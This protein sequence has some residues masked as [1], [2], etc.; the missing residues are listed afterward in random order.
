MAGPSRLAG[1]LLLGLV[2]CASGAEAERYETLS[3]SALGTTWTVTWRVQDAALSAVVQGEVDLAL[4]EVDAAMSTWRDDSELAAIR[5]GGV[6]PVSE[7]TADV[8]RVALQIAEASGGAF[9]PTVQPLMEL[10]GF[11]GPVPS[12]W[13]SEQAIAEARAQIGWGRVQLGRDEAGRA[14]VDAGGAALDL[15]AIAKGH[16][17]DRV[18]TGLVQLG[19][20]DLFVEVG[21]E[22][23]AHGRSPRGDAWRV[24]VERPEQGL[25]R[26]EVLL[27]L[28]FTNRAVATSGN[29]RNHHE[30]EGRSV[31]HTM[32][33][34][35]GEASRSDVLSA[36]VFAPDCR[37]AD[38]WAT[39]LMVLDLAAGKA[40]IEARPQLDAIWVVRGERGYE[41]V[42]SEGFP[43]PEQIVRADDVVRVG[44]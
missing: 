29:Y 17:V 3:G 11:H 36:T 25:G 16:A 23:R 5:R 6:V 7:E 44:G 22:V 1:L 32:D 19:V 39:A 9:D 40:M 21:G 28:S 33:P 43:A 24:G 8:V 10:W 14:T 41:A 15:S 18:A 26:G 12:T 34:R 13:P 30:I 42:L 20:T 35:T 37:E 27:G 38:G 31:H 4:G 2:G